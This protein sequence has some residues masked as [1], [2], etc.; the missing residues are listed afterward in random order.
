MPDHVHL[1][2]WA[3][4][5]WA[6]KQIVHRLKGCTSRVLRAEFPD[7]LMRQPSLWSRSFFVSTAG[8]VAGPTIEKCIAEQR[9]R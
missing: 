9:T 8:S 2:V 7:P 1:F 5:D 6:P 3:S 4:P